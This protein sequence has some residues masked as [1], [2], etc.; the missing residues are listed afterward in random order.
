M[1]KFNL[2]FT[3]LFAAII[4]LAACKKDKFTTKPQL[5]FIDVNLTTVAFNQQLIF[6][7]EV[8]DAEGDI[9]DTLYFSREIKNFPNLTQ[10]IPYKIPAGFDTT[11]NFKANLNIC[12]TNGSI[13]TCP[14]LSARSP[15]TQDTTTFKFWMKDKAKNYSDTI[16]VPSQIIIKK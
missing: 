2:Y 14:T 11:K 13:G 6:N 8:T 4:L 10:K 3:A 7:I 5:K 15:Q 12:F 1:K 16:T 9:S